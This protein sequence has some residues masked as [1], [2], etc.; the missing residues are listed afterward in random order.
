MASFRAQL[1]VSFLLG[2]LA[3]HAVPDEGFQHA[4]EILEPAS[5]S[6]H[7]AGKVSVR[8]QLHPGGEGWPSKSNEVA[9]GI[10]LDGG[11]ILGAQTASACKY[12]RD[13]QSCIFN[14][15]V[16][17][18]EEGQHLLSVRLLNLV[19]EGDGAWDAVWEA[20]VPFE[21][22][23]EVKEKMVP[24][25]AGMSAPSAGGNTGPRIVFEAP[26]RRWPSFL[27]PSDVTI[28]FHVLPAKGFA[29]VEVS[30]RLVAMSID[31]SVR[32]E[33]QLPP[34]NP[35]EYAVKVFLTDASGTRTGVSEVLDFFV[36]PDHSWTRHTTAEGS[37]LSRAVSA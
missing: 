12:G 14:Q 1:T 25:V 7:K 30:G 10:S 33:V 3:A 17:L 35:G 28:K 34:V 15:E 5:D 29:E 18:E 16:N 36:W 13:I 20:S 4:I 31:V 26:S 27:D 6:M 2:I 11:E 8:Y 37:G 21:I 9:V 23:P 22:A 32:A 24:D 19:A